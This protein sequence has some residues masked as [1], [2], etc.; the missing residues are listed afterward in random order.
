ML[1]GFLAGFWLSANEGRVVGEAGN[2]LP[3]H[4][5]GFHA[6]QA[7][8]LVALMLAWSRVPADA[9]RRWVHVAGAAWAAACLAVWWQTALG[10]PVTDLATAAGLAAV[11]L[12][13][14]WALAA[15]RALVAWRLTTAR[16]MAGA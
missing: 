16:A 11:V 12:L 6:V 8:P 1:M 9:A 3:L 4:A 13:G 2:L 5:A 14:L 10:R 7:V 15:L